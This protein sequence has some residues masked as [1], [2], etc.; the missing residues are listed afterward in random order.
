[1]KTKWHLAPSDNAKSEIN[2]K[3]RTLSGPAFTLL[4]Y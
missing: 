2:R 3:S 1:M 4:L